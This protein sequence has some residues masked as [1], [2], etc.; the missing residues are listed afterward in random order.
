MSDE[1]PQ[2]QETQPKEE[3]RD[4]SP[5]QESKKRKMPWKPAAGFAAVAILFFVIGFMIPKGIG[6]TGL[7]IGPVLTANEAGDKAVDYIN[8]YLLQSGFTAELM[9]VNESNGLYAIEINI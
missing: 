9:D 4:F 2:E 3:Q 6:S 5:K 8:S 7:A 1:V